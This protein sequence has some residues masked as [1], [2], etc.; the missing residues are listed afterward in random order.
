LAVIWKGELM[1]YKLLVVDIDGT[2][3]GR[4]RNISAENRRALDWARRSGVIVALSTGRAM[5]A[6]TS[7]L[8]QLALD[9]YHIFFDGALVSDLGSEVYAQP[10]DRGVVG[11]AV[12]FAHSIDIDLEL[13]SEANYFVERETW[14]T[15]AHRQFFGLE[16]SV[17]DFSDLWQRERIIKAGLASTSPE[18]VAKARQFYTQFEGRLHFSIARSPAFPGVEFTNVV[19]PEVSKGKALEALALHL[20]ILLSEVMAVGDG[21]NDISL[22]AKAGLAVA[23]ANAPDEVK[24]VAD[25]IAPDVDQ[26]GLAAAVERFLR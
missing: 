15:D 22:L 20:G 9:G 1:D 18:Q 17:V 14:S 11:E 7:I 13:Y 19:A 6:C 12:G 10:L 24:A 5:L 3:L 8:E 23:M 4:E 25:H 16:P 26:N 21:T 2:L